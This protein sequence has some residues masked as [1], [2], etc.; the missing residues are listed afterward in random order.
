MGRGKWSRDEGGRRPALQGNDGDLWSDRARGS[1]VR[2]CSGGGK[3]DQ[4]VVG[5]S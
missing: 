5:E 2:P 1:R 3:E 4:G